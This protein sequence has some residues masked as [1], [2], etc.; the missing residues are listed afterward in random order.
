MTERAGNFSVLAGT[1]VILSVGLAGCGADS[2][3]NAA[4][5]PD[6]ISTAS[7]TT[8]STSQPSA[9]PAALP[10]PVATPTSTS[11]I[12]PTATPA[13]AQSSSPDPAP[14]ATPDPTPT[15][16]SSFVIGIPEETQEDSPFQSVSAGQSHVCGLR[17][18]G[19]A[20]CWGDNSQGQLDVP[21]EL[22]QSI[23]AGDTR[24]CGLLADSTVEC[25]GAAFDYEEPKC[26][27]HRG[28]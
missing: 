15:P 22:F 26:S 5:Q 19:T 28:C 4:R 20:Y 9:S 3:Q 2:S 27:V 25:W 7:P 13:P 1:V 8:E 17:A 11:T 18:N 6:T 12:T 16:S 10:T 14:A 23:F 24:T 21:N